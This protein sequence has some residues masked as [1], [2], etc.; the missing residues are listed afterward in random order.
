[1]GEL[2]EL[3]LDSCHWLTI[4]RSYSHELRLIFDQEIDK[5]K[6]MIEPYFQNSL[7]LGE[8]QHGQLQG[9]QAQRPKI[10]RRTLPNGHLYGNSMLV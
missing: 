4:R 5:I 9:T 8:Q 6:A 3:Y 7:V 2:Q 1:M 10:V